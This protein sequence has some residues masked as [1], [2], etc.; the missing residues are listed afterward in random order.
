MLK[1]IWQ[2]FVCRKRWKIVVLRAQIKDIS[3]CEK[4]T[5]LVLIC[6]LAFYYGRLYLSRLFK[7]IM[8]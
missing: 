1:Q 3:V 5:I 6:G 7:Q 8:I 4:A 2:L